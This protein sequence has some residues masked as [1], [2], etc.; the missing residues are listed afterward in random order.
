[1]ILKGHNI[2]SL[3]CL[4]GEALM[5][6]EKST[7]YSII[8]KIINGFNYVEKLN[9]FKDAVDLERSR[10]PKFDHWMKCGLF[11]KRQPSTYWLKPQPLTRSTNEIPLTFAEKCV[12]NNITFEMVYEKFTSDMSARQTNIEK[13]NHI[14]QTAPPGLFILSAKEYVDDLGFTEEH[15]IAMYDFH[16]SVLKLPRR[17]RRLKRKL[18]DM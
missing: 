15:A 7:A 13:V 10:D 5:Y 6:R 3:V 1:M 4:F 11:N 2:D 8:Q 17:S 12:Q 16:S 14:I 18:C 9:N